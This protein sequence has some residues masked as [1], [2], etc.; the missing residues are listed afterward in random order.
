MQTS[1]NVHARTCSRLFKGVGC[2]IDEILNDV[3]F[4]AFVTWTGV[5]EILLVS[6]KETN[7][8]GKFPE[9]RRASWGSSICT[10]K[11]ALNQMEEWNSGWFLHAPEDSRDKPLS[12]GM[13]IFN[14]V[15]ALGYH[16]SG[17]TFTQ[18]FFLILGAPSSPRK[19]RN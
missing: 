16:L 10:G 6:K 11:S 18:K 4:W 13:G 19:K 15:E 2:K 12:D 1:A 3:V 8:L 9:G 7:V 5:Q 14:T 17:N